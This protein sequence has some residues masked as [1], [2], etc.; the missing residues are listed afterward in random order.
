MGILQCTSAP[1]H[2]EPDR[3]LSG[4]HGALPREDLDNLYGAALTHQTELNLNTLDFPNT[5]LSE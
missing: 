2:R 3:A 1:P 4:T 5:I